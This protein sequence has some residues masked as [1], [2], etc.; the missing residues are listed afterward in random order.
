MGVACSF[1]RQT[2]AVRAESVE[3]LKLGL[4]EAAEMGAVGS[5]LVPIR[6]PEIAAPSRRP[7]RSMS[8]SARS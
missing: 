4:R 8:C 6:T 7:R 3:N 2:P 5:I 1:F